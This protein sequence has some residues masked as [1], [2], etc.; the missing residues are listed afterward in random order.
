MFILEL[1]ATAVGVSM[2]AFSV[3]IC[4]GLGMRRVNFIQAAVIGL[5]FG[6]FQAFMPLIGF[7]VVSWFE[8]SS[9]FQTAIAANAPLVALILLVFLGG[10]MI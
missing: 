2:D 9:E 3:S 7:V 5:V 4:K 10:K 8:E 1:I 6:A